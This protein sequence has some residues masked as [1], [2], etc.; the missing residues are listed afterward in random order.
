MTKLSHF[1]L[2]NDKTFG[3]RYLIDDTYFKDGP[4]IFFA[5]AETNIWTYYNQTGFVSHVLPKEFNALVVYGEHRYFGESFPF[6]K[7][8]AF[9]GKNSQFMTIENV[10][11]DYLGILNQVKKQYGARPVIAVGESYGAELA[12]WLRMKFPKQIDAALAAS[13]PLLYRRD[14]QDLVPSNSYELQVTKVYRDVDNK[15][16]ELIHEGFNHLT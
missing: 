10:L 14:M 4:I 16:S 1:G 11:S 8:E 2:G 9:K 7:E 12:A 13:A 6:K 5:G 15:C 3:I